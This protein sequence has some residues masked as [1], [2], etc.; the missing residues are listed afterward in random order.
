MMG[1]R[2]E[3][4][5]WTDQ[6]KQELKDRVLEYQAQFTKPRRLSGEFYRQACAAFG[7][8]YEVIERRVRDMG[9]GHTALMV[10]YEI[11]QRERIHHARQ[12]K[13]L[14]RRATY[15]L[16]T[17]LDAHTRSEFVQSVKAAVALIEQAYP[18]GE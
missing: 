1:E 9:L 7:C 18:E 13:R 11:E 3:P 15:A 14:A 10:Q 2:R 8:Y 17:N 6:E 12:L 4:R 16:G 5:R